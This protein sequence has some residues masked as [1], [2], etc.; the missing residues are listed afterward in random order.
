MMVIAFGPVLAMADAPHGAIKPTV[1]VQRLAEIN[2]VLT[3]MKEGTIN[4]RVVLVL[5]DP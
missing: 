4:G 5:R 3:R 1:E 2:G